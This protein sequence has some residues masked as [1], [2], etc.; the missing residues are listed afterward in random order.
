MSRMI[1]IHIDSDDLIEMLCERVG[2]WDNAIP[3]GAMDL[4]YDFYTNMVEGGAYDDMD[5]F[6]VKVIV[7]NDII[8]NYNTYD[9]EEFISNY[10]IDPD[11]EE[12]MDEF[13]EDH[14][15]YSDGEYFIVSAY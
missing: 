9:K 1:T 5:D 6:D 15:V 2:F 8:N 7:D 3:Y 14:D 13:R 12:A 4:W 10:D 11:D